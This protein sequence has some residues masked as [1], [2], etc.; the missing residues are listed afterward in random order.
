MSKGWTKV[1]LNTEVHHDNTKLIQIEK[2]SRY[3]FQL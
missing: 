2:V 1:K 3:Y